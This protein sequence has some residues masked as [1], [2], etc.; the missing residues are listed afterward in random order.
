[1]TQLFS[2]LT[3]LTL[4]LVAVFAQATGLAAISY[5]GLMAALA[6]YSFWQS[7]KQNALTPVSPAG[8]SS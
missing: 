1:M 8:V 6:A 7:R 4:F 5:F 2:A 3:V